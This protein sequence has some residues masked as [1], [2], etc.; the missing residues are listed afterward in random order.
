M[1]DSIADLFC[2]GLFLFVWF[3]CAWFY[4]ACHMQSS[5][6]NANHY[7][8]I[9]TMHGTVCKLYKKTG[10]F[11]LLTAAAPCL[12]QFLHILGAQ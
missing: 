11:V 10:F 4:M 8:T 12:D 3:L 7:L 6:T 2:F 9:P 1:N 5:S